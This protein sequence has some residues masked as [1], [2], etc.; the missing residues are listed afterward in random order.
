MTIARMHRILVMKIFVNVDQMQNVLGSQI[1]VKQGPAD[2]VSIM[3]APRRNIV[4]LENA[5]VHHL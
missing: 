3:N 1:L 2:V 5:N 4:T